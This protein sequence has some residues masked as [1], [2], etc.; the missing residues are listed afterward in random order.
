MKKTLIL[1]VLVAIIL[2]NCNTQESKKESTNEVSDSAFINQEALVNKLSR[3]ID[4]LH[5]ALTDAVDK[6]DG[7]SKKLADMQK[8]LDSLANKLQNEV[9]NL[10]AQANSPDQEQT[11]FEFRQ[12]LKNK[13]LLIASLNKRV[14]DLEEK[15]RNQEIA[16]TSANTSLK[17]AKTNITNIS[18]QLND[19]KMIIDTLKKSNEFKDRI[20]NFDDEFNKMITEYNTLMDEAFKVRHK[21]KCELFRS[22]YNVASEI[23]SHC[24]RN[25][26]LLQYGKTYQSLA[27]VKSKFDKVSE[28]ANDDMKKKKF[29]NC[30]SESE[31]QL[32]KQ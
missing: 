20:K 28:I 4:S 11:V 3:K 13:D 15:L 18:G 19:A 7:D 30:F 8:K 5:A 12:Q 32:I 17:G 23:I 14:S 24:T 10:K 25:Q 22:A 21:Y 1:Y 2:T 31:I 9:G 27:V 6:V 16:L 29:N 26:D